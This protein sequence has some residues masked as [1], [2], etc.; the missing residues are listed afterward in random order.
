MRS[1]A[2]LN[3]QQRLPALAI[4]LLKQVEATQPTTD[5]ATNADTPMVWSLSADQLSSVL[6][7]A[8]KQIGLTYGEYASQATALDSAVRQAMPKGVPPRVDA[9]LLD[10]IATQARQLL[11]TIAHSGDT[12]R[13]VA[14][15]QHRSSG[16]LPVSDLTK[17]ARRSA[18]DQLSFFTTNV[19]LR[20]RPA[21]DAIITNF[22]GDVFVYLSKRGDA[23]TPGPIITDF[24]DVLVEAARMQPAEALVVLSHSMGGQI[25]YDCATYY[26]PH[27]AKYSN[28][29]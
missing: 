17:R 2:D 25:V 7:A 13:G 5:A 10:H 22:I 3:S 28:I 12:G 4:H 29:G 27:S 20:W 19:F 15:N 1:E 16:L 6:S 9:A 21:I 14:A 18:S 26:I 8:L 24:L 23:D 11:A